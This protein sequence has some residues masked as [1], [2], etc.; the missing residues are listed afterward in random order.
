MTAAYRIEEVDGRERAKTIHQFNRL[1][2]ECFPPL[3]ARHLEHGH[4]WIVYQGSNPVAFAG[5]VP[6]EPFP[7]VGYLKRAYVMQEHRGHALQARL[8]AARED[9]ARQLGWTTL[10]SECARTNLHSAR[11]FERAGFSPCEPEQRWG[12]ADSVYWRKAL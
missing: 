6:F 1:A 10:V 11:N 12:A 8:M 4:W 2:P 5:L 9:K 7:G 3:Q